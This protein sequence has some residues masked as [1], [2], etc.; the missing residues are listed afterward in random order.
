[1]DSSKGS[2]SVARPSSEST[3]KAIISTADTESRPSIAGRRNRLLVVD[4]DPEVR[5]GLSRILTGAAYACDLAGS[6]ADA[7]AKLRGERFDLIISGIRLGGESDLELLEQ[8]TAEHIDVAYLVITRVDDPKIAQRAISLGAYGYIV[9][10]FTTNEVVINVIN[11]LARLALE[12]DRRIHHAELETKLTERTIALGRAVTRLETREA[13]RQWPWAETLDRLTRALTLRDEETGRH[14]ERVGLYSELLAA[15]AGIEK[16]RPEDIRHAGM[17]HDAG[18]IG[19]S[20]AILTKPDRLSPEERH[21]VRRHCQLGYEL[22]TGSEAPLLNLAASIALTHH[23]HWD[24]SGYPYGLSRGAIPIEGRIVAVVDAFDAMTSDRVYRSALTADEAVEILIEGRD[25]QFDPVLV[26]LLVESLDEFIDIKTRH[27]DS[28]AVTTRIRVVLVDRHQLFAEGMSVLLEA[29]KDLSLVGVAGS[30]REATRIILDKVPDVIVLDWWLPDGTGAEL[31]RAVRR[32][33]P[34]MRAVVV[35]G[36]LDDMVTAEAIEVGCSAVL[37]K[38]Q[39]FEE[40]LA[41]LR[42]AHAG[43]VTIPL[44]K[45]SSAIARLPSAR[46]GGSS[47]L[48]PRELEVLGLLGEGLSNEAIAESLTLSTNTVRNHVQRVIMKLNAHSKLEAV[49]RGLRRGLIRAPR[50]FAHL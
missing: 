7:R 15:K 44:A 13:G 33:H 34:K 11:A 27:P 48:T 28:D 26:D 16:F 17:L 18:K 29:A 23:E 46:D 6:V 38:A 4:D 24:G 37:T 2:G 41:A 43:D 35:T 49:A 20:D 42:A 10:P 45:L 22:L 32:G 8:V 12:R 3:P 25:S 36:V 40:I 39:P 1:M 21:V 19:V 5:K 9:Q 50:R 14:I 31:V 47:E 30:V